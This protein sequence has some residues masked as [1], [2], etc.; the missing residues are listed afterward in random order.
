V[1]LS[2]GGRT[3]ADWQDVV[4]M[5]QDRG[6]SGSPEDVKAIVEYLAATYPPKA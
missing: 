5:M 6:F 3:K 1:V 4:T 2:Q